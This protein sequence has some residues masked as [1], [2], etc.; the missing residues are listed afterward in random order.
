MTLA[1][2]NTVNLSEL[3]TWQQIILFLLT[4]LGSAILVSS[5]VVHV[6]LR[7]FERR[8]KSIVESE[9]QKKIANKAKRTKT[10]PLSVS[11]GKTP[12]RN[13]ARPVN[14][15]KPEVD[16]VVVRGSVIRPSSPI[17]VPKDEDSKD[18][19]LDSR[20]SLPLENADRIT[21]SPLAEEPTESDDPALRKD[22]NDAD[23]SSPTESEPP[24]M[25]HIKFS[26]DAQRSIVGTEFPR[27]TRRHSKAFSLSGVGARQNL[28]N[29]PQAASGPYTQ[30]VSFEKSDQEREQVQKYVPSSSGWIARNS[31]FHGLSLAEREKLGGVEYRAILILSYVVPF[32]FV[33]CQLFGAIA[34]GA[35]TAVNAPE[36]TRA[37]GLNPWWVGVFNAISAFNNNG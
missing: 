32:Y 30:A 22:P 34:V 35:W 4:L 29:D 19:R 3:N 24:T 1:G 28:L 16:G 36:L 12:S 17:E 5:V 14:G 11:F 27:R 6:R 9:R 21:E 31:Q 7:A 33:S 15:I 10:F 37:N 23:I 18:E 13:V 20:T 8:F 26:M 2:L 25:N